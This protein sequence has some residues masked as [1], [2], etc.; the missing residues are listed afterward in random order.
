M[1]DWGAV[2]AETKVAMADRSLQFDSESVGAA[3][4]EALLKIE[5]REDRVRGI[6]QAYVAAFP[7]AN[8][9]A[10]E[11]HLALV[12]LGSEFAVRL[13]NEIAKA[14]FEVTRPRVTLLR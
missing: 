8:I 10:L 2:A 1:L 13:D 5:R 7:R 11:A 3:L 14:G 12:G 9:S 4:R 6:A